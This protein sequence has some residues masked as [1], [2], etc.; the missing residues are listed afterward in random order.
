MGDWAYRSLDEVRRSGESDLL[1]AWHQAPPG[2]ESNASLARRSLNDLASLGDVDGPSL[3]VAHG[4]LIRVVLGL[5]DGLDYERI[6]R[7]K[8]ENCDAIFRE[9]PQGGFV[10]LLERHRPFFDKAGRLP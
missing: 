8:I 6:G 3:V 9:L 7:V 10:D 4:G 1:T 2:G 5:I